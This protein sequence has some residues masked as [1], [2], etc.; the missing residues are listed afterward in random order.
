MTD[1]TTPAGDDVLNLQLLQAQLADAQAEV[2]ALKKQLAENE[3]GALKELAARA[4]ADLQ[5]AR[6]RLEREAQEMRQFAASGVLVKLLPVIDNF[7][8]AFEHLPSELAGHEWVKGISAIEGE[9]MKILTD[10]GVEVIAQTS[11]P[12]DTARHDVLQAMPGPEG[13]VLQVLSA[14]Y[15]LHGRVLRP[16]KVMV[17]SGEQQAA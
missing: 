8:L 9:F 17:G 13:Q 4:Q 14:G 11:V 6:D 10:L 1:T 5:N 2:E 7:R 12:V 15:A 3:P 16:A